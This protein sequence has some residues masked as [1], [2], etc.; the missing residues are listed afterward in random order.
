MG[1][2]L[3]PKWTLLGLLVSGVFAGCGSDSPSGV[4]INNDDQDVFGDTVPWPDAEPD[5]D[6]ATVAPDVAQDLPLDESE[7]C[8]CTAEEVCDPETETCVLRCLEDADCLEGICAV[9]TG[10]CGEPECS[11]PGEQGECEVGEVCDHGRCLALGARAFVGF[12]SGAGQM[13]SERYLVQGVVSPVEPIGAKASSSAHHLE[14]GV[15]TII[16]ETEP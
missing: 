14:T 6:D 8:D 2:R 4:T 12:C 15:L 16:R 11:V 13:S 1:A 10:L 5:T 3:L 9:D 7:R